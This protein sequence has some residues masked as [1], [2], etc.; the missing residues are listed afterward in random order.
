MPLSDVPLGRPVTEWG[1]LLSRSRLLCFSTTNI[2]SQASFLC[3]SLFFSPSAFVRFHGFFFFPVRFVS[4][5]TL[6]FRT[7]FIIAFAWGGL[8]LSLVGSLLHVAFLMLGVGQTFHIGQKHTHDRL[9]SC[10]RGFVHFIPFICSLN[11]T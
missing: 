2:A 3:L 4:S 1:L 7:F 9:T 6:T 11:L 5:L 8:F 10:F